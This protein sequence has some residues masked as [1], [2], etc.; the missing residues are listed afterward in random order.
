MSLATAINEIDFS[1]GNVTYVD[2]PLTLDM[3]PLNHLDKLKEDMLQVEYD[4]NIIVDVGWYPSR[5]PHGRF[6]LYVIQEL[7][8]ENPIFSAETRGIKDILWLL[9]NISDYVESIC[10][11]TSRNL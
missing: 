2:F 4:D 1:P 9:A 6:R 8:W 11:K 3:P 10:Q 5:D 7:D